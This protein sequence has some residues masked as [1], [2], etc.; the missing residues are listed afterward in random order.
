ME[1]P[2]YWGWIL[3]PSEDAQELESLGIQLG[4]ETDGGWDDFHV[5]SAA[6]DAME[7]YWGRWIWGLVPLL[8]P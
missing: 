8:T 2:E 1:T 3:A 4:G 7:P 5:S 6:L